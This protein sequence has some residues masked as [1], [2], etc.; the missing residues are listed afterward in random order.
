LAEGVGY[1]RHVEIISISVYS[2]TVAHPPASFS[3]ERIFARTQLR[4]SRLKDEKV[5]FRGITVLLGRGGE[6]IVEG[7]TGA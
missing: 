2:E 7:V 1:G 5:S 4:A 3:G 6:A